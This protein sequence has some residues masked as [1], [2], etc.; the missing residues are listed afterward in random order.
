[1][2]DEK[3]L[4][5]QRIPIMMSESEVRSIDDWAFASRLR[6]RGEAIRRLCQ[7][8]LAFERRRYDLS[9]NTRTLESKVDDLKDET[10]A[11][12][13]KDNISDTDQAV[14][15]ATAEV[16]VAFMGVREVIIDLLWQHANF[17]NDGDMNEKMEAAAQIEAKFQQ[18]Y[19]ELKN[20]IERTRTKKP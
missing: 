9:L 16:L 8:G 5:D 15:R 7:L 10:S 14:L 4:K 6:S 2:G 13:A 19:K 17:I 11:M 12:A 20:L 18:D 1:M 3:E